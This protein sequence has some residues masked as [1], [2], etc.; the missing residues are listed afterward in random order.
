M[1]ASGNPP[2][3]FSIANG[4]IAQVTLKSTRRNSANV[5]AALGKGEYSARDVV[6]AVNTGEITV[7][8]VNQREITRNANTQDSTAELLA[9][10]DGVLEESRATEDFSFTPLI[11]PAMVY[12]VHFWW[13]D[14][15]TAMYRGVERN[16]RL[17]GLTIT[18]DGNGERF[19]QW[20]F[21]TVP[22]P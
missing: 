16:K 6:F 10:A 7:G 13:T 5:V 8:R 22:R 18:V 3:V 20:E 12:G 14:R 9:Y 15:V 19:S 1:N 21:A 11:T 4:N 17:T 2:V